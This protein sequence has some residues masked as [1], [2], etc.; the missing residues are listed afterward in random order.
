MVC[1]VAKDVNLIIVLYFSVM[2]NKATSTKPSPNH[3]RDSKYHAFMLFPNP[4][5]KIAITSLLS[6]KCWI[7]ILCS[8][9]KTMGRPIADK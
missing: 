8:H 6:N 9:F 5:G 4:V 3:T 2:A 7:Y 1:N